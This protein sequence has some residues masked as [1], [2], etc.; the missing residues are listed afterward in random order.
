M[1]GLGI[2]TYSQ[3][4]ESNFEGTYSTSLA[5]SNDPGFTKI[6]G[7]AGFLLDFGNFNLENTFSLQYYQV[8]YPTGLKFSTEEISSFKNISNKIDLSYKLSDKWELHTTLSPTIAS[9]LKK[10]LTSEDFLLT[11]GAY[12]KKKSGSSESPSY[13][14]IG[15]AYETFFGKPEIY[16][17]ISYYKEFTEEFSAEIGFP[18]TE[19]EYAPSQKSSLNA[20]LHF[21]GEYMNLSKPE[22]V[23]LQTE[24]NKAALST[25]SLGLTYSYRLDDSWSFNLGGGYLLNNKYNLLDTYDHEV[26]SFE[27]NSQ[28]FFTTGIKFNLKNK[29]N[30]K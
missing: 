29:S 1:L 9:T 10:D 14:K 24:A 5:G 26:F 19:L 16:P 22:Y 30:R 6:G 23:D 15:A 3:L 28:P 18:K 2:K 8:A 11:G 4:Q 21:T 17:I 25:T 20:S 13:F 27:T 12:I 7:K